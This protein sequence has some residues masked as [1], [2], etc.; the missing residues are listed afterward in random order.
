MASLSL[1][2][3]SASAM[4]LNAFALFECLGFG[5]VGFEYPDFE[6]VGFEP[7]ARRTEPAGKAGLRL[8]QAGY[9]TGLTFVDTQVS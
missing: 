9:V 3:R 1:N 8:R 5:C 4:P 2:A 6:C 7:N